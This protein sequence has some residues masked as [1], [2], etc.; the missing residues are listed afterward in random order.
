MMAISSISST[1]NAGLP[2]DALIRAKLSRSDLEK[3]SW[4]AQ[5]CKGIL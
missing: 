5:C 3:R 1:N 4:R 2:D